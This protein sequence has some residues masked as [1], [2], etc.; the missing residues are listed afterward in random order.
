MG[1]CVVTYRVA[2]RLH[3]L[4][5]TQRASESAGDKRT[6]CQIANSLLQTPWPDK[7]SLFVY[8]GGHRHIAIRLRLY[9]R[10][11]QRSPIMSSL[12]GYAGESSDGRKRTIQSQTAERHRV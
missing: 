2:R 8:P 5:V 1:G 3:I 7:E 12:S 9:L 6:R 4:N 10:Q 11:M